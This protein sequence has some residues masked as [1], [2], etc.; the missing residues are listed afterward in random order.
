M[1]NT[2]DIAS[3][4]KESAKLKNV[5]VKAMLNDLGL[6]PTTLA[7][8]AKGKV[9]SCV[10]LAKIA[11]YLDCPIDYLM[12]RDCDTKNLPTDVNEVINFYRT[13]NVEGKKRI[14]EA[15]EDAARRYPAERSNLSIS[16]IG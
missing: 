2:Q 5:T 15:A 6:S 7:Q 8:F 3:R 12:G 13:C 11:D 16:K 4:I 1:Y 10:N 9:M 14:R